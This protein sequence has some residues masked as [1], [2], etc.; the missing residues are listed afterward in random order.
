MQRLTTNRYPNRIFLACFLLLNLLLFLPLYLLNG[1][2]ATLFP[3]A[4]IFGW[5]WWMDLQHI[6]LWRQNMD[7]FR[8]NIEL[9][10]L[11]ALWVNVRYLR[12]PGLRHLFITLYFLTLFYYVYEAITVSIYQVEPIFYHHYYLV[13]DGLQFLLDHLSL[14]VTIYLISGVCFLLALLLIYTFAQLLYSIP[15]V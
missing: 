5:D 10:I 13:A 1:E 4:E 15:M 11:A 14:S 9:V 7:P 8:W 12:R 6:V 3:I 2:D